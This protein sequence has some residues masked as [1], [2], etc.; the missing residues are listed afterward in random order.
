MPD[1]AFADTVGWVWETPQLYS[2]AKFVYPAGPARGRLVLSSQPRPVV[3]GRGGKGEGAH[4]GR[5]MAAPDTRRSPT[6]SPPPFQG[7]GRGR[8]GPRG[9]SQSLAPPRQARW[10]WGWGR[11]LWASLGFLLCGTAFA[12][13]G[14]TV[15]EAEKLVAGK[16]EVFRHK[17]A[18]GGQVAIVRWGRMLEASPMLPPGLYEVTAWVSAH[19]VEL[20]HR[21][22][23]TFQAGGEQ[24]TAQ[25]AW[26]DRSGVYIP[27]ILR[28]AHGGGPLPL[29]LDATGASG[30]DGMRRQKSEEEAEY[31]KKL[32]K[33]FLGKG[34]IEKPGGERDDGL[35]ELEEGK[36]LRALGP[37]EPYVACDRI[38]IRKLADLAAIV[39]AVRVDKVHYP[40]GDEVRAEVDVSQIAELIN[41]AIW[42]ECR[43]TALEVRERSICRTVFEKDVQLAE[44]PTTLSFAYKPG[45]AEFGR[46][47]LVVVSPGGKALEVAPAGLA[48]PVKSFPGS[49]SEVFGVSR[50]VYR[51]GITG[52]SGGH[53]KAGMTAADFA[54][55]MQANKRAY[56]NHFEVFAWAP[57]DYSEMTPDTEFF[58][59]G[60]TQYHG[61]VSAF[62]ALLAEAHKVGVKGITYGKACAGGIAGWETFRK[63]PDFFGIAAWA[64]VSSDRIGVF[65]CERMLR[66][67]HS[68]AGPEKGE[69]QD[70]QSAWVNAASD[71]AVDLGADEIIASARMFGWDGVRWDGHFV[72]NMVRFKKRVDA[73]LPNFIHGYNIAFANPG[74][75]LF[76][77][78]KNVE[79]FHECARGHGLMMDESVRDWSHT[80]FSP[81]HTRPDERLVAPGREGGVDA[82]HDA[83]GRRLLVARRAVD[84]PGEEEAGQPLRLQRRLGLVGRHEVVGNAVAVADDVALL[85]AANAADHLDLDLRRQCVEQAVGVDLVRV[86][87]LGLQEELVRGLLGEADDFGL[88]RGAVARDGSDGSARHFGGAVGAGPHDL[89]GPLVRVGHV[90]GD[91]GPPNLRR[92]EGERAGRIV[93]VLRFEH[94]VVNRAAVKAGRRVGR[95]AADL[96]AQSPQVVGDAEGRRLA[97]AAGGGLLL[98]QVD[99][100]VE[101][102]ARGEDGAAAAAL[103]ADG[104]ADAGAPVALDEQA[105]DARLA[106]PQVRLLLEQELHRPRVEPAIGLGAGRVDGWAAAAVEHAELD[107]RRVGHD[108]HHA[109]EGVNLA[110]ELAFRQPAD[111]RVAGHLGDGVEVD[112]QEQRLRAQASGGVGR[113]AARMARADHNHVENTGS[114]RLPGHLVTRTVAP[115]PTPRMSAAERRLAETSR[116]PELPMTASSLPTPASA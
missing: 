33:D 21:L 72:G 93:A 54:K 41:S 23:V 66:N 25:A 7:V 101:E 60:Q 17:T 108:A 40:P 36:D 48:D 96:E 112:R 67:E 107:A 78:D 20:L 98:A 56:A 8:V 83:L 3:L 15:L 30:F 37:Q 75:K 2:S 65:N 22:A 55:V 28:V 53:H 110:D 57:C 24:R 84:L 42:R 89:V 79:D 18:S 111:G 80:N 27:I 105:A 68:L 92:G 74:S 106:E 86:L 34:S 99:H 85:Q 104:V 43:I 50:N 82:G 64:G 9:S 5:T 109:A 6:P 71:A 10:G 115:R 35:G 95:E 102:R 46:E 14:V 97:R 73:A 26:F 76:L 32:E 62:K 91:V 51:I 12:G 19:P 103:D 47:L 45:D 39:S 29:A 49:R 70:W 59:S 69:W 113:L 4:A 16:G 11:V 31:L 58:L 90:A 116:R 100:A 81:G 114:L 63:H 77:P 52:A 13:E 88:N 1:G 94:A 61:S 87:P 44:E 38:E